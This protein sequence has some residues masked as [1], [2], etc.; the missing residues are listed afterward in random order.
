[1]RPS[2]RPAKAGLITVR[3][4]VILAIACAIGVTAG[5]LTY[6]ASRS[7][8]QALL[9]A[10]TAIGGSAGWLAQIF[11]TDPQ[12]TIS[13]HEDNEHDDQD[14]GARHQQA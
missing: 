4:G 10:G 14:S 9:A 1:M 3:T 12:R 8:P 7:L 5:V 13:G 11:G 2:F 6:L